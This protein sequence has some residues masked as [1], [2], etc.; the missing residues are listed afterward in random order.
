MSLRFQ[1]IY[2]HRLLTSLTRFDPAP[3]LFSPSALASS[4]ITSEDLAQIQL[5][6]LFGSGAAQNSQ[7]K[8]VCGN[9]QS[10]S[11]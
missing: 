4:R 11:F 2:H 7:N 9:K 1:W 6:S 5:Y 3:F 10:D 8:E